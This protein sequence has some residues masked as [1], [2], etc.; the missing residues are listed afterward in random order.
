MAKYKLV[1]YA[2][3]EQWTKEYENTANSL[4]E[5]EAKAKKLLAEYIDDYPDTYVACYDFDEYIKHPDDDYRCWRRVSGEEGWWWMK[6]GTYCRI[7]FYL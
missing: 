4:E 7:G 5:A 6:M 2:A 3:D 1:V